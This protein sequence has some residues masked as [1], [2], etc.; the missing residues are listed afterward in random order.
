MADYIFADIGLSFKLGFE[1]ETINKI[2]HS[3]DPLFVQ[4]KESAYN[5][6]D[7]FKGQKSNEKSSVVIMMNAGSSFL[8]NSCKFQKT[9]DGIKIFPLHPALFKPDLFWARAVLVKK[10]EVAFVVVPENLAKVC[11]G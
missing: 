4:A 3:F 8:A 10:D 9:S 5:L 11:D 6:V 1:I 7:I 2:F